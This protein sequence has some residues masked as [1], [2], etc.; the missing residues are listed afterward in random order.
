MTYHPQPEQFTGRH[1][2]QIFHSAQS[3]PDRI[4]RA[5]TK[6]VQSTRI[7][8]RQPS[9][10]AMPGCVKTCDRPRCVWPMSPVLWFCV[11]LM[12]AVLSVGCHIPDTVRRN[13]T[14]RQQEA[15]ANQASDRLTYRPFPIP[16]QNPGY[17]H[18]GYQPPQISGLFS[19]LNPFKS[20]SN[21]GANNPVS[22]MDTGSLQQ[23]APGLPGNSPQPSDT[24]GNTAAQTLQATP[25]LGQDDPPEL[26]E[27]A[28]IL[29]QT[30]YFSQERK[31]EIIALLRQESPALRNSIMANY[32]AAIRQ[33]GGRAM[34]SEPIPNPIVQVSH[35]SSILEREFSQSPIRMADHSGNG[36]TTAELLAFPDDLNTAGH[37]SSGG[38]PGNRVPSDFR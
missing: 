17:R 11:V 7:T 25:V 37:D 31:A 33:S 24:R 28:A 23:H 6:V 15:V 30:D 16:Q 5:G 2:N 34:S 21:Q 22:A 32:L 12:F 1:K 4:P 8:T 35:S 18:R 10:Q 13:Q 9:H 19:D 38:R 14:N 27:F 36:V 3:G 29:N 26:V 20:R